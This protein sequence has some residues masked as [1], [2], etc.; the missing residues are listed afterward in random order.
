[1]NRHFLTSGALALAVAFPIAAYVAAQG[2]N[3]DAA[4]KAWTQSRTPDGQPDV[5]GFWTNSTYTPL[6]R[7][8]N[9]TKEFYSPEEAARAEKEAAE[10]EAEQTVP[11]TVA[12]VHYDLSQFGLVRSQATHSRDLRTGL[13]VDS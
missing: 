8:K 12:D 11:G 3:P 6:E 9:V 7:P 13:I 5:Q 2:R 4:K 1:M 10:R